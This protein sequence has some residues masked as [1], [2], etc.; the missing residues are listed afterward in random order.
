MIGS[1]FST[2]NNRLRN[3][4]NLGRVSHSRYRRHRCADRIVCATKTRYDYAAMTYY[5]RNLPHWHPDGRWIF[6]TW[7]LHGSLPAELLARLQETKEQA[8][9]RF[10]RAELVLDRASCGP[11][12]LKDQRVARKVVEC[13]HFGSA[14]LNFYDSIAYVV[15]PNHV[16]L[17]IQPRVPLKRITAGIKGVSSR[18]ANGVLGRAGR[19]F[20]QVESFDHWVRN[21][22][23]GAKIKEYIENNPVKGKLVERPEDW[24]WSSAARR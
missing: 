24:P 7:R 12:W 2:E 8:N 18:E 11:L 1:A 22:A 4:G 17:L 16:H 14:T 13:I 6:V 5:E 19:T 20:W 15:M 3:T 9:K 10:A 21:E 23:E